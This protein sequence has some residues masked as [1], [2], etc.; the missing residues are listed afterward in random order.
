V[1][2]TEEE[3]EDDAA[4]FPDVPPRLFCFVFLGGGNDNLSDVDGRAVGERADII[5]LIRDSMR[6]RADVVRRPEFIEKRTMGQRISHYFI[7]GTRNGTGTTST[8]ATATTTTAATSSSWKQQPPPVTADP[9]TGFWRGHGPA[10]NDAR[11]ISQQEFLLSQKMKNQK[12]T[13]SQQ[14]RQRNPPL[15]NSNTNSNVIDRNEFLDMPE[16]LRRFIQD[17]GPLKKVPSSDSMNTEPASNQMM[18]S[19]SPPNQQQQQPIPF[20]KDKATTEA[21]AIAAPSQRYHH[22]HQH[23]RSA[24]TTGTLTH[25]PVVVE[26]NNFSNNNNDSHQIKPIHVS[27]N[28]N[29]MS[30][31]QDSIQYYTIGGDVHHLYKFLAQKYVFSDSHESTDTR[32]PSTHTYVS[33][34][35]DA[36]NVSATPTASTRDEES[37]DHQVSDTI[38]TIHGQ[39]PTNNNVVPELLPSSEWENIITK[40]YQTTLTEMKQSSVQNNNHSSVADTWNE[41]E[42]K[43]HHALLKETLE[44]LEIP[45]I[46]RDTDG[47]FVGAYHHRVHELMHM[48][49]EPLSIHRV[50][51]VM[52]DDVST[53]NN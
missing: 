32:T 37:L 20:I 16:E 18:T 31:R 3:E 30:T 11:D 24:T 21:E 50:N 27:N 26:H 34:N 13:S 12:W 43:H 46:M 41:D 25:E 14:Q 28:S 15:S 1:A 33:A 23:Q 7:K 47:S 6:H 4:T 39:S 40:Y 5:F 19:S 8:A 49:I 2:T 38:M 29:N 44:A 52:A 17:V 9:I 48:K 42:H 36:D 45:I 22:Q 35:V 51:V 10:S 53:K